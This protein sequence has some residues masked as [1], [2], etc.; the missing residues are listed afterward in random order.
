MRY[1]VFALSIVS[2][3]FSACD[4][5]SDSK[6]EDIRLDITGRS[7][8]FSAIDPSAQPWQASLMKLDLETQ[9]VS[10]VLS[11]ESGDAALFSSAGQGLFFNRSSD[12]QNFRLIRENNGLYWISNQQRFARGDVGDPHDVLSLGNDRVLLAHYVQGSLTVMQQST[13]AELQNIEADWDLPDGATFKPEGFLSVTSAGRQLIY[14]AHQGLSY[15]GFSVVANGSQQVF[16]LEVVDDAVE[17]VDLDPATPKV[18]GIKLQG[19]FP[20]PVHFK[21]RDKPL[22]LSICSRYVSA[23]SPCVSAIEEVDPGTNT[24]SVVWDLANSGLYMNGLVTAG[25]NSNTFFVNVEQTLDDSSLEKRVVR[26]NLADKSIV[27]VHSFAEE[28]GGYWGTFFDEVGQTLYVSDIGSG[29]NLGRFIVVPEVGER[30]EIA[31]PL[32]PYSATFLAAPS[33]E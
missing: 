10:Q 15:A 28:S 23:D 29:G 26:M 14:V 30:S 11:G 6:S 13:G 21:E 5:K 9:A 16:V 18:Q 17:V 32:V 2:C 3:L 12:S 19:S 31:L 7:L 1:S 22:F 27:N 33:A 8:L 24:A 20:V 4:S 25:P